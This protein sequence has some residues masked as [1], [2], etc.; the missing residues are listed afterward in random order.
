MKRP[1]VVLA[2]FYITGILIG[3]MTALKA[4]VAIILAAFSFTAAV[5]GYLLA[6]QKN[7][8]AVFILFFLLGLALSRLWIEGSETA[9]VNYSGQRVILTGRVVSEPDVREDKVFYLLQTQE[10]KKAEESISISGTVRLQLKESNR[11]FAYGDILS[12]SGLL[13]RPDLAGNPGAFDYRSYLERQGIRVTLTARGDNA[14]R[15]IGAGGANPLQSA[16]LAVKQKMSSAAT[17]SL[18][19]SHAAVLNGIVFGTQGM[20]DRDTRRSFSETGVIHILSV[21]GLH[22]GLVLGGLLMLLNI[23]KLPPVCTAPLAT[24]VLLIYALMT[25]MN[26]AV[27]RA[28]IMALLLVWAHHFGRDRDWPTT[29]AL[30][31]MVILIWNPLQIYH[32][33]F[34]LSFAATWGILYLGPLLSNVFDVFLRGLPGNTGRLAAQA[35][36]I[37]LAAQ[38]ATIPLVAWYYNLISPVSIPA[39][40]LAVPLTGLIMVFG[41]L[42]AF[43]GMIW[44]PLAA[45]VN[46]STS[47]VLDIFFKVV[48]FMQCL[49][50]AVIYLSTPPVIVAAAWYGGL[51]AAVRVCSDHCSPSA[52]LLFKRWAPVGAA[53][54]VVLVLIWWPW[55]RGHKM[56][57][58]FIDVGQGDSILVQT[59]GR[60]NILIDTGGRP[61]EFNTGTGTGDQ[62]VEPYLRRIGVQRIDILVLT[63]PHE[64][65][66]GGAV[67]LVKRFP[68]EMALVSHSCIDA[69]NKEQPVDDISA[70]S[71]AARSSSEE[72]VPFAYTGLLESMNVRGIPVEAVA[73]GDKI[74]LES[75]LNIEVLSPGETQLIESGTDANNN[76]LVIKI[77]YGRRSFIFMGDAELEEQKE[78]LRGDADIRADILKV[79]HHGSRSLLEELLERVEAETAVISVGAHNT[80]GHPAQT[81]LEMLNYAGTRVYRTDTDGA[82]IIQTDGNNIDIVRGKKSE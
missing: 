44:L 78:L 66:C 37:P 8:R 22:V 15:K 1:M 57:V 60:K 52:R 77:A 82:V 19:P 32:P 24:P 40:L 45:L 48:A 50:G 54:A 70:F 79:P 16:A 13:A 63:H 11:I 39:N 34:Q 5:A 35:L 58:H 14:V 56:T 31:A 55:N 38:L 43:L 51:L 29:L 20:I 7:S 64:D 71:G 42:A 62:V 68:V 21:S 6:W 9:L 46:V 59:P 49:P 10:L 27:M 23:M 25:G 41:L 30:A 47:V 18:T 72:G 75:D 26:P 2:V 12:V 67:S 69:L 81:T 4:S 33:G 80:F 36:A 53:L 17:Y 28:V 3:E 65:H 61:G 74:K 76:S 73:S